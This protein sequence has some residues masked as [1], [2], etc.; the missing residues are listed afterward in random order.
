M[1]SPNNRR[2]YC[3]LAA[4]DEHTQDTRTTTWTS[5]YPGAE[6]EHVV[7]EARPQYKPAVDGVLNAVVVLVVIVVQE[8]NTDTCHGRHQR[9]QCDQCVYVSL[10]CLRSATYSVTYVIV[11]CPVWRH[12]CNDDINPADIIWFWQQQRLVWILKYYMSLICTQTDF[13]RVRYTC[14]FR[15]VPKCTRGMQFH[16]HVQNF[17][18]AVLTMQ[19]CVHIH[20]YMYV[21][22]AA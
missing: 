8:V 21:L 20:T 6:I 11:L 10:G 18:L 17:N 13:D 16:V 3:K 7:D 15:S 22:V 2:E 14:T 9:V 12:R 19:P 5:T 4:L 1:T